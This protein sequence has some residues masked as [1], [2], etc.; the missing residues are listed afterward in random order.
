MIAATLR[1]MQMLPQLRRF[2]MGLRAALPQI[3][4]QDEQAPMAIQKFG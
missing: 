3:A 1:E 2:A 4:P